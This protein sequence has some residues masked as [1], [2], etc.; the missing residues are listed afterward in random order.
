MESHAVIGL[1]RR[2]GCDQ[3]CEL[4]IAFLVGQGDDVLPVPAEPQLQMFAAGEPG[5]VPYLIDLDD[6]VRHGVQAD[7][8]AHVGLAQH[9]LALQDAEGGLDQL[10]LEIAN[11]GGRVGGD[12]EAAAGGFRQ[13]AELARGRGLLL[14]GDREAQ[15]VDADA[16]V[17]VRLLDFGQ[18][19]GKFRRRIE[20][21]VGAVGD[22][23]HALVGRRVRRAEILQGLA[24]GQVHGRL[25]PG[26]Q[27][28]QPPDDVPRRDG[29]EA[30]QR[31]RN[32]TSA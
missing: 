28:L 17:G 31:Q 23:D 20:L 24:E 18:C 29:I 12:A 5:V 10:P 13:L 4:R 19:R 26:T 15:D 30:A 8:S 2:G 27:R 11:Q 1:L 6:A 32:S 21:I 16:L 22:H 25:A 9:G 14:A 3:R 7:R